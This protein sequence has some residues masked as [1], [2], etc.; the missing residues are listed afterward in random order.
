MG[1]PCRKF[2]VLRLPD[3]RARPG[4][5]LTGTSV[6]HALP[7]KLSF[8]AVTQPQSVCSGLSQVMC[9]TKSRVH[10]P[11]RACSG[12][13]VLICCF[14]RHGWNKGNKQAGTIL[15][16][17]SNQSGLWF[18]CRLCWSLRRVERPTSQIMANG[19]LRLFARSRP[20][21]SCSPAFVDFH[22]FL[23]LHS[24]LFII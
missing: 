6:E 8:L 1:T 16:L 18:R 15:I 5:V 23:C 4:T 7:Q 20:S 19:S 21:R 24:F 3:L 17:F 22:W 2:Q 10:H 12:C 14:R 9:F 11:W 13:D